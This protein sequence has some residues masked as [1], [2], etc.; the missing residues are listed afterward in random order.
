MTCSRSLALL[1]AVLLCAG[2]GCAE[3][4]GDGT[5]SCTISDD[6]GT[7]EM[8]AVV[9]GSTWTAESGGYQ[10]AG[11]VGFISS[12]SVDAHNLMT[13]RLA[14]TAV[15]SVDEAGLIDVADGDEVA[16]VFEA[17]AG[18][19][20]FFLG[21][22]SRDGGDVT[23]IVDDETFH[24]DDG[25]GGGFLYI[26]PIVAG[27]GNNPDIVRGCF[28]FDAGTDDSDDLV[29]VVSGSFVVNPL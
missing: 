17:G 16:D 23:L 27:E 4:E 2:S 25:D 19:F 9:D 21:S 13:F 12:F 24:T 29:N 15:F 6:V 18:P 20:E 5:P 8:I 14:Q 10:L 1:V 3:E 22:A 28:Y 26:E 7:N 11:A